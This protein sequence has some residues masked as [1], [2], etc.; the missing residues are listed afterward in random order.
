MECR[1]LGEENLHIKNKIKSATFDE[2]SCKDNDDK[3]R[4]MTGLTNYEKMMTVFAF[5][6]PY[7]K[8]QSSLLS[9]F[10]QFILTLLR[11]RLNLSLDFLGYIFGVHA[12]T[13][14]RLFNNTI[15]VMNS[16]L[17]PVL[18]FWPDRQELRESLPMAL[19]PMFKSCA[20]I[21]LFFV[22]K[23]GT[24]FSLAETYSQYKHH[25]TMKYLIRITYQ[26]TISFIS[27]GRVGEQVINR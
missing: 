27:K 18:V 26:E 10:Q 12:T 11:L 15:D 23:P 1:S 17:I 8:K 7:L 21:I 5:V 25:N 14:S 2:L 22:E 4:V 6:A 19:R 16:R 3:V 9:C 24:L 13:A 20:C